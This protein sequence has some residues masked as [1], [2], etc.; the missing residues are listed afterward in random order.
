MPGI[1]NPG[2]L[3][4]RPGWRGD[5]KEWGKGMKCAAVRNLLFVELLVVVWAHLTRLQALIEDKPRA[6]YALH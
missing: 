4:A 2:M 5:Q 3:H 6:E 1:H